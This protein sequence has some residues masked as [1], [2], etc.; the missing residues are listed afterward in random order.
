[1]RFSHQVAATAAAAAAIVGLAGTPATAAPPANDTFGGAIAIDAVPYS[2]T[3]DTTEA[4]TDA[5]DAF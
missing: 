5:Q 1:M 4:T 2:A 3:L